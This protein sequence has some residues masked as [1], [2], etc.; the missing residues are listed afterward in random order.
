MIILRTLA[1][2][3]LLYSIYLW[4]NS[5][6]NFGVMLV[7]GLTALLWVGVVFPVQLRALWQT[8]PGKILF[9]LLGAGFALFFALLAFVVVSGYTDRPDGE[10][11]AVVVLGAALHGEKISR[12][13]KYRLDAAYDYWAE[14]PEV[15]L[16]TA[17]GQGRGED[18]PEGRAMRQYLIGRGVPESQVF[19]E[20]KSTSTEE[21]F[22]FAKEILEEQG[23]GADDPI[24]FSTNA[25]HCYRSGEYAKMA[26]FTDVSAI[27]AGISPGTVMPSYFREVF[28]LLY[29]WCFKSTK[30]G[31]MSH[32]VGYLIAI[33]YKG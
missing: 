23:I 24:A 14:N 16:V 29:Y 26:G 6:L 11:K 2:L 12:I 20:E 13:L 4:T 3:F 8:L 28:A 31:L 30:S 15:I 1:V 17:G 18:M 21:N 19:A 10:E 25:F 9:G 22:L 5:N 33:R 27:P 32:F 7:N